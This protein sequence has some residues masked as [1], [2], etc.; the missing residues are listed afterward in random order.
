MQATLDFDGV[1]AVISTTMAADATFRAELVVEGRS[2]RLTVVNPL[3]PHSGHE[4]QVEAT[5]STNPETVDGNS[6]YWHQLV[7]VLDVLAGRAEPITGGADAVA[8]MRAID[9]IYAAAG[10]QPR[11]SPLARA[12]GEP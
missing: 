2:G 3:A 5:G 8:T 12:A 1:P 4:I 11:G 10:M 7:H 6:T 9:T